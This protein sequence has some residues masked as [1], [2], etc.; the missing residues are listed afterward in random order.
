MQL[1]KYWKRAVVGNYANF[2]GRDSRPELWWFI[3]AS[4]LVSAALNIVDL[5]V[6]G[7]LWSLAMLVPTLAANTRRL[8]D[9]GRSGWW[10]LLVFI[11]LVGGIILI[12]WLASAGKAGANQYGAPAAAGQGSSPLPPPPPPTAH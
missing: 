7:S 6:V 8:H 1:V 4:V 2:A 3:L 9:T 11:P 12:V 5:A 10:Q